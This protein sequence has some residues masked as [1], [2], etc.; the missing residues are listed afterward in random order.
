MAVLQ[1]GD[2]PHGH[3]V[4]SGV[5]TR[6]LIGRTGWEE[7]RSWLGHGDPLLALGHQRLSLSPGAPVFAVGGGRGEL[8]ASGGPMVAL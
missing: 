7:N 5:L 3:A 2:Q 8:P 6:G 4:G 1:S